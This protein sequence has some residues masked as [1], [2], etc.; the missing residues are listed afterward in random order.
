MTPA[1]ATTAERLQHRVE[2]CAGAHRLHAQL[3]DLL[4][5]LVEPLAGVA[6]EAERLDEARARQLLGQPRGHVAE[7]VLGAAGDRAQAPADRCHGQRRQADRRRARS[8]SASS[9]GRT[10]RSARRHD[11]Q[12][13]PTTA[14]IDVCVACWMND[15]VVGQPRHEVARRLAREAREIRLDRGGRRPPSACRSSCA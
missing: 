6:L 9:R 7:L 13:V 8:A 3:V 14:I 4:E 1:T 5:V 11:R 2:A 10:W 15:E 12:D